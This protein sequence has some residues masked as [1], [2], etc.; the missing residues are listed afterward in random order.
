MCEGGGRRHAGWGWV[1]GPH[2][3][4]A[5]GGPAVLRGLWRVGWVEEVEDGV[6]EVEEVGKEV[7]WMVQC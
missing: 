6:E 1:E 3:R 4:A 5:S 2:H 7:G